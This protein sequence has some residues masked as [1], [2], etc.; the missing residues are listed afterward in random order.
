MTTTVNMKA[1]DAGTY[2]LSEGPVW[3]APAG[4]LWWVDIE[5]GAVLRAVFTE[6]GGTPA[7]GVVDRIELGEYV[8]C[9][10]PGP[11]GEVLVALTRQLALVSGDGVVRRSAA[12][13]PEGQRFNDG[14]VD[15]QGRLVVGSLWL[16]D[17]DVPGNTLLRLEHD[18]SITTIDDDLVLSN[19]LGWSPDGDVFYSIDTGRR[20]V[21]RRG[22]G[23]DEMGEREAFLV[24]DDGEWPDGMAVDA[25]GNLWIAVWGG[26][27]VRVFGADGRRRPELELSIAA[28]H[29][30][31]IAFAGRQLDI[32]VVTSASRDLSRRER[33]ELPGAGGLFLSRVGV[34]GLPITP[35]VVADLPVQ[36]EAG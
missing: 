13:L 10:I 31:S 9:A 7:L 4:R 32:A 29:C 3:D 26:S 15:P 14:K 34:I 16:G 24:F 12:L 33:R 30:S 35:W 21:F 23:S 27:G 1:A 22:Y 8:G 25:D 2:I 6:G 20:T 28:P 19:G 5:D 36:G 11:G 18:G 17:I